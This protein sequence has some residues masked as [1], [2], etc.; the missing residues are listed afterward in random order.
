[1]TT[2][3]S[4]LDDSLIAGKPNAVKKLKEELATYF[5]CKFNTPKDFLGLDITIP[6]KGEITLSMETFTN[7]MMTALQ[8]KPSTMDLY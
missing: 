2:K 5:Q 1:M 4:S 6:K 7:R 3:P 8:F